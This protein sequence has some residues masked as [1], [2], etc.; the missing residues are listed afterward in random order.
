MIKFQDIAASIANAEVRGRTGC[1]CCARQAFKVALQGGLSP[2][3]SR[4][5][6]P[7]EQACGLL[8]SFVIYC[9]LYHLP[10]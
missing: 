10:A 2:A 6:C 9:Q 1:H 8:S 4:Q 7:A 3:I 5:S